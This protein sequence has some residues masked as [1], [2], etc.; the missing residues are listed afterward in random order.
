MKHDLIHI[1]PEWCSPPTDKGRGGGRSAGVAMTIGCMV[2]SQGIYRP[3]L[4]TSTASAIIHSVACNVMEILTVNSDHQKDNQEH[5]KSETK[6][7]V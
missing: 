3:S 7:K 5:K 1:N 6:K 2:F 4:D